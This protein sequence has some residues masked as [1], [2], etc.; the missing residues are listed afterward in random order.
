MYLGPWPSNPTQ[1][2]DQK[3]TFKF[4][5]VPSVR[6]TNKLTVGAGRIFFNFTFMLSLLK[7]LLFKEILDFG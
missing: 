5:R 1:A 6:P 3:S 2:Q 7:L 4:P